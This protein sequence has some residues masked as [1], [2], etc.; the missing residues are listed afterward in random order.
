VQAAALKT[1]HGDHEEW[2]KVRL[3]LIGGLTEAC[4]QEKRCRAMSRHDSIYRLDSSH[5][6]P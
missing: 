4:I 3:I 1:Q 6:L 5:S 2:L